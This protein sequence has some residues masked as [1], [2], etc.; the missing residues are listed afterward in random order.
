MTSPTEPPT[1][2]SQ[3]VLV[4]R[5]HVD[6]ITVRF[7]PATGAATVVELNLL[8]ACVLSY[9]LDAVLGDGVR[10]SPPKRKR[11]I[12]WTYAILGASWVVCVLIGGL[13][14]HWLKG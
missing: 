11:Q 10:R 3:R 14:Q 1:T 4:A 2:D 6:V 12:D 5:P 9:Q 8:A 7:V 13:F